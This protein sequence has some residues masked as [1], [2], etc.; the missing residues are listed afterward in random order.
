MSDKI[1]GYTNNNHG[2]STSTHRALRR[3][4][5]FVLPWIALALVACVTLA[6]LNRDSWPHLKS[7]TT[8]VTS[9][10]SRMPAL[11]KSCRAPLPDVFISSPPKP[12]NPKLVAANL[13]FQKALATR[14]GDGD[15]DS[16]A[17]AV[18]TSEGSIFEATFGVARANETDVE[19]RGEVTRDTVY[20][21]ASVTKVFT[22]L[23]TIILR[24]RGLLSW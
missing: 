13:E 12:D 10:S 15:I 20:R 19:L 18:V 21:L 7:T 6:L 9:E 16:L 3:R 2:R 17:L 5:P 14:F 4:S 11:P 23:E 24:D 22:A 8:F 1:Q